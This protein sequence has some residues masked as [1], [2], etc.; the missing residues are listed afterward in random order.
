MLKNR[1]PRDR[2]AS[3]S[4]ICRAEANGLSRYGKDLHKYLAQFL[5]KTVERN[6]FR[7]I[8]LKP[9][10]LDEKMAFLITV[11][12]PRQLGQTSM[13]KSGT[14]QSCYLSLSIYI[15]TRNWDLYKFIG[16]LCDAIFAVY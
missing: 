4:Q 5:G 9:H 11:D 8:V 15:S 12:T 7:H 16:V 2:V 6:E 14:A 13:S 1:V 3:L 10:K